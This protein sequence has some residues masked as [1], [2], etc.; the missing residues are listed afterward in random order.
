MK[1]KKSK[2]RLPDFKSLIPKW[3]KIKK[4][5]SKSIN[6]LTYRDILE[7]LTNEKF[8]FLNTSDCI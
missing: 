4:K 8:K 7:N 3:K 2:S 1:I 6:K 5:R